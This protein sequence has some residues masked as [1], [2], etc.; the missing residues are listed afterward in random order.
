[1]SSEH[2]LV[3]Y[4]DGVDA[5]RGPAERLAARGHRRVKPDNPYWERL[6]CIA[7]RDPDGWLLILAPFIFS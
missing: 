7:F 6:G 4:F 3:L 1:V 5:M 2:Q